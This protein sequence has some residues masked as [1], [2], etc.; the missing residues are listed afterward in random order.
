MTRSVTTKV[1]ATAALLLTAV[2]AV[3]VGIGREGSAEAVP[4]L[5]AADRATLEASTALVDSLPRALAEVPAAASAATGGRVTA[6]RARRIIA[7][8]PALKPLSDAISRPASVTGALTVAFHAVLTNDAVPNPEQL[9]AA[10]NRMQAVQGQIAPAIR[11]VSARSGHTLSAA[12]T[13]STVEADQAHASLAALI[14]R[15]SQV[16]GTFVLIEQAA[17]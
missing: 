12:D 3:V 17:A 5:T 4:P 8:A 15:W 14:G 13:L 7:A 11:L 16:Y 2:A 9:P 6:D 10:L 1:I